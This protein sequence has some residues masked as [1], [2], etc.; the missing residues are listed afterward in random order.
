MDDVVPS[1]I[2]R[3]LQR[4]WWLLLLIMIGGGIAG[5]LVSRVQ[6]PLYESQASIT[7]SI[8]FAYAGRLS[9]DEED[10]LIS[11]VGDIIDSDEVVELVLQQAEDSGLSLTKGSMLEAFSKSRQGYRWELSVRASTPEQAR[12]LAQMWVE[13]SAQVLEAYRIDSLESLMLQSAMLSL[14]NCFS[15][16]VVTDPASS[17]CS[18]ENLPAIRSALSEASSLEGKGTYPSALMLSKIST[19]V[20]SQASLPGRPVHFGQ[21]LATMAG[22]FCGLLIGLAILFYAKPSRP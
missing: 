3:R 19:A 13:T 1:E 10:Y 22:A 18:I 16:A 14:Q 11:S 4:L 20:T 21:N 12:S 17:W 2:F 8:D 6:K 5:L 7:T 15:Q 9:D